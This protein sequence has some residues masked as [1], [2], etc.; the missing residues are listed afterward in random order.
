MNRLEKRR[1]KRRAIVLNKS[2]RKFQYKLDNID[3][4]DSEKFN[5]SELLGVRVLTFEDD[6]DDVWTPPTGYK[7]T[8]DEVLRKIGFHKQELIKVYKMIYKHR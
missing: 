3:F 5:T 1:V 4:S 6:E 8:K 7:P 2:Y